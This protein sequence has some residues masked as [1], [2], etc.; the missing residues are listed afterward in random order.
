[1]KLRLIISL[2]V[3]VLLS[4]CNG[5]EISNSGTITLDNVLYESGSYYYSLG[6][7]FDEG[8]AVPTLPDANRYDIIVQAGS[9]P[10]LSANTLEPAFA[11]KSEYNSESEAVNAFDALTFVGT[12]SYIDMAVPLKAN[13]VWVIRTRDNKYAKIR[14]IDVTFD[15][16]GP[17][18]FASCKL[19]WVFQPD[20][21]MQF[22]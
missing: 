1:M 8:K 18:P 11:L 5:D 19:E 17:D 13:Q 6:L 2:V 22:P 16:S 14:T 12:V 3:I 4:G 9:E 20:G 15:T 21:S 7:S 10:F